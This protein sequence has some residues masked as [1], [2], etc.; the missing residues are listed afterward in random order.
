MAC[1]DKCARDFLGFVHRNRK[2]LNVER[3]RGELQEPAS[4]RAV[5]RENENRKPAYVRNSIFKQ[6]KSF[7]GDFSGSGC[8]NPVT[9]PS[10]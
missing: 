5:S 3:L 9:F 7:T 2:Q 8:D 6:L 10:G 4:A 1:R